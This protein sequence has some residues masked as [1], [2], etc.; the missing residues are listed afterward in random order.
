MRE[1]QMKTMRSPDT[2]KNV[3]YQIWNTDTTISICWRGYGAVGT[4]ISCWWECRRG[5]LLWNSLAI[6]YKTKHTLVIQSNSH[7]FRYLPKWAEKRAIKPQ[8]DIAESKA[9]ILNERSKFKRDIC[10]MK[11]K[12]KVTQLCPTLYKVMDY[13]VHGILQSR[14]LE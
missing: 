4:P 5:L 12:V 6:S 11:V 13:A 8:E 9:Y 1:I 7:I 2:D 10:G 3:M 14:I